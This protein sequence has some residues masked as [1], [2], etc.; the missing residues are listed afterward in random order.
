LNVERDAGGHLLSLWP[1]DE[2]GAR[3]RGESLMHF[4]VDR[5][6]E[7][8]ELIR[9]RTAVEG[10]LN[11]VRLCVADWAAMRQRMSLIADELGSRDL[12]IE[13]AGRE[14]AQEFL[15]WVADEHFTFLGYREYEVATEGSEEVLRVMPD[16]GL[17]IL[18][19]DHAPSRPLK[20][21]AARDLPQSGA[22]DALI[23]SKTN[24]RSTVHRSGYMDYI[25]ILKFDAEGRPTGEQRF[26]G[27]YTSSAYNRRPWDIPVVR[28]KYEAVMRASGIRRESHS[29][30][31]LR[32]ILETLPRDE[33]FQA[34]ATELYETAL[35]ILNLQERQRTRL[36]VRRDRYGRFFSCLCSSRA[37][38]STPRCASASRRCSRRRST[39][40]AWIP[41]SWWASRRSRACT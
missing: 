18:R 15:R 11:D 30:K 31:A 20:T 38:A 1:V 9:L 10:A 40:S 27:L 33:L 28:E 21:L 35:G 39:A 17:G 14:E 26:L 25:G 34:Q 41:P 23:L 3:G 22:I 19:Q 5:R 6:S 16:S 8:E 4:E 29:G 7:P 36:F 37:T 32:N 13:R 24:A 12:P 2:A